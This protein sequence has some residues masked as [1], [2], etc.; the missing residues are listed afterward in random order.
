MEQND[1]SKQREY[2]VVPPSIDPIRK[3]RAESPTVTESWLKRGERLT[4]VQRIG[5]GLLSFTYIGAGTMFAQATYEDFKDRA[6]LFVFFFGLASAF[7]F[8]FGFKGMRNVLR[9]KPAHRSAHN[10]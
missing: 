10:D 6:P 3:A 1:P 5:H 7:F 2:F 8:F 9:F 4:T